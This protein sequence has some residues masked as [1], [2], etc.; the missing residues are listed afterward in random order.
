MEEI[1]CPM[2]GKSNPDDIEIC[3]FCQARL[4]PMVAPESIE[5]DSSS[6]AR[7]DAEGLGASPA[8]E[9]P[10]WLQDIREDEGVPEWNL[11]ETSEEP[12]A[13]ELESEADSAD[14]S[15]DLP[16]WILEGDQEAEQSHEPELLPQQPDDAALSSVEISQGEISQ[17]ETGQ[18]EPE[19]SWS[20]IDFSL[21]EP[22]VPP[23]A[24]PGLE[25]ASVPD[26]LES[27]RPIV[28]GVSGPVSSQPG[29]PV[30]STGPLAGLRGVLAAD[31]LLSRSHGPATRPTKL[32][33]S[34][35]QL[36]H[37]DLLKELVESEGKS[38]PLPQ[39]KAI[40]SEHILRWGIALVLCMAVLWSILSPGQ[41]APL[42]IY[43][44][45]T[46]ELNRLIEQLPAGGRVLVAFDYQP[47]LFA[48]LDSAAY[49]VFD[50]LMEQGAYL[51]LVSSTAMGPILAERFVG[52][53]QS[54]HQYT[55]GVQYVNLGYIPGGT[56]GL[57][58]L[59]G[60]LPGTLP[61]T[62]N[63]EAAWG[64]GSQPPLEGI[65]GIG[66]YALILVLVDD[67]DV[68]RAWVEQLTP[69]FS[70]SFTQGSLGMV[71]SAQI[72]PVVRPYFDANPR[73][74][75]GFV[76]G[77]R[78]GASYARLMGHNNSERSFW[79]PFGMGLFM[80]VLLMLVGAL[81]FSTYPILARPTKPKNEAKG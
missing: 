61:Y 45:E 63:G 35:N 23:S 25:P 5:Q 12:I 76:A 47:G 79:D 9:T 20:G 55:A 33:I 69:L 62:I 78:G 68:A 8:V 60:N 81:I 19:Q 14:F 53:M 1:R 43:Q 49:E 24:E 2:C 77:L 44:E 39:K 80:G 72:E 67:P 34:A 31:A 13:N 7:S 65:E 46:A 40:S 54:T 42:P 17:E 38:Q 29:D 70:G 16:E 74:L 3:Q 10:D 28:Q 22:Q 41:P 11:D 4:R 51:T 64:G 59:I 37:V 6:D 36:V 32:R 15:M 66:D 48:E 26:W 56:A 58:S 75:H 71:T 30:E 50:H 21:A 18:P 73:Q 27:I 52:E 57:V